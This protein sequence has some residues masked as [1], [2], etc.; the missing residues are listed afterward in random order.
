MVSDER[1]AM[2]RFLTVGYGRK[3]CI[4]LPVSKV[5]DLQLRGNDRCSYL[6]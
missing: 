1:L 2:A 4:K 3:A 6:R 5:A